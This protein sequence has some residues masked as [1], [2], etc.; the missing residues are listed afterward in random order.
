MEF[1]LTKRVI[2]TVQ[3]LIEFYGNPYRF[4]KATGITHVNL[5]NWLKM[6]YIP[7]ASQVKIVKATKGQFKIR[8]ED[9]GNT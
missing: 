6:G 5:R 2:M 1:T 4:E 9:L 8:L 3:E 7:Y